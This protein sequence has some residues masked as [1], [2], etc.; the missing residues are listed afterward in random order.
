MFAI[1][2]DQ[3]RSRE[4]PDAVPELLE[5]LDEYP[6]VRRFERTAGDEVQGLTDQAKIAVEVALNAAADGDWWVGVGIGDVESPIPSSVRESRGPALIRARAAVERAHRS[7]FGVAVE[8]EG[9][10][11]A[12]TALQA[13]AGLVRDRSSEGREAVAAIRQSASQK[14]A[15]ELLGISPQAMSRRLQVARWVDE[16]RMRELAV[17][18]MAEA[19]APRRISRDTT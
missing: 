19:A 15:A 3:R 8:G 1:T 16:D 17:H 9:A 10:E 5:A 13:L 6:L 18:L 4:R 7:S 11:H 12:E 2:I 14:E